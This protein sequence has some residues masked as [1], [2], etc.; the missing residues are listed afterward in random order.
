MGGEQIGKDKAR[1]CNGNEVYSSAARSS[2][3]LSSARFTQGI[4]TIGISG[5][6]LGLRARARTTSVKHDT[7]PALINKPR[8]SASQRSVCSL[9]VWP[10]IGE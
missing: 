1:R 3:S 8:S 10:L 5:Y 4:S 7:S 6:Y 9:N 2:A